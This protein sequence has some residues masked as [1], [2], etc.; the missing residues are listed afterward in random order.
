MK[1]VRRRYPSAIDGPKFKKSKKIESKTALDN[2][3]K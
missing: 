1:A 2:S 3:G